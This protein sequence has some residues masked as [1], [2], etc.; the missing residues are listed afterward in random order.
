MPIAPRALIDFVKALVKFINKSSDQKFKG[1]YKEAEQVPGFGGF[2]GFFWVLFLFY[3]EAY[4][5][6][7]KEYTYSQSQVLTQSVQ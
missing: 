4:K 7:H 3:S 6:G 2:L 1:H 5:T